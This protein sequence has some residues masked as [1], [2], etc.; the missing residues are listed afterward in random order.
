[1]VMSGGTVSDFRFCR[2]RVA[3]DYLKPFDKPD[4]TKISTI[5]PIKP[6]AGELYVINGEHQNDWACD[7]YKW[8]NKGRY[9]PLLSLPCGWGIYA[10]S[11][12]M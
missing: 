12:P 3:G 7:G 5:P 4:T 10:V 6:K 8:V 2:C 9:D 1:M 11:P